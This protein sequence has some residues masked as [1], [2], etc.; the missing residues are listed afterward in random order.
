MSILVP[1]YWPLF[2]TSELRRFDYTCEEGIAPFTSVFSYDVGSKSMLYNNYDSSLKWLNRW[3]YN[4]QPGF[5]ISEWRDDYPGGKKVVMDPPIG[6]G[7]FQDVGTNY[8][9][10]PAFSPLQCWPPAFGSGLQFVLFEQRLPYYSAGGTTYNDVLVFSYLQSWG[11]KAATGC[12]YWMALGIGPVACQFLVQD[13]KDRTK[14]TTG[15]LYTA[16]VTRVNA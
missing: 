16:K 3:Y 9:N 12:R 8:Q 7:E 14:G 4:Y 5:G 15:P 13:D 11:G 1:A 10:K 2:T 6:W